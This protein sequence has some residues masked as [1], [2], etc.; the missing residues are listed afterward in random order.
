MAG[1]ASA[2]AARSRRRT[3]T[4]RRLGLLTGGGDCAGLNAAIRAVVT[5]DASAFYDAELALR[6][7]FGSPPYGR[8]VKLTIGLPD[9]AGAEQQA[10]AMAEHLRGRAGAGV[11]VMGPAPA[12]VARR[13]GRWR[14]NLIL[15]GHDPVELLRDVGAP[16]SID[17]DPESLL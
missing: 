1:N 5:G 2:P 15:R 9:R 16:W 17:V 14:Y 7:R 3:V 6:Q 8:L 11:T 13:S 12:Y 4:V 10:A